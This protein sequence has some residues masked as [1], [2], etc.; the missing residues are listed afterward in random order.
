MQPDENE[1][2]VEHALKR[3]NVKLV[4]TGLDFG[5][6]GFTRIHDKR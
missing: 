6:P 5:E 1:A 3:R 2:V 4:P